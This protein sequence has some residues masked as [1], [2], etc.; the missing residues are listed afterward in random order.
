MHGCLHGEERVTLR[1]LFTVS[2]RMYR[3]A[4]ALF[5]HRHRPDLEVR[6]APPETLTEESRRF[7]PQL[8]VRND[9][10]G[11]DP[12]VLAQIPYLIEVLYSDSMNARISADGRVTEIQ[13]I[14]MDDLLALVDEKGELV[15]GA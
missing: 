8:V 1:V 10:D 13:D 15:S 4:L 3:E 2:P 5:V 9:N 6:V 7:R 11:V 12:E 14:S